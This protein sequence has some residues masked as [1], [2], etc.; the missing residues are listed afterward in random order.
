MSNDDYDYWI[1]FIKVIGVAILILAAVLI[2]SVV[3]DRCA[4]RGGVLV[5]GAGGFY[6][7]VEPK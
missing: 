2:Y 4:Q 6:Q 5:H 7:C 1:G 3:Y